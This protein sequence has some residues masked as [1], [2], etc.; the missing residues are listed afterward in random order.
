MPQTVANYLI[1]MP[2][3]LIDDCVLVDFRPGM[4]VE[5][6]FRGEEDHR[7]TFRFMID[8]YEKDP[9][10]AKYEL[11]TRRN[12]VLLRLEYR[13][14]RHQNPDGA[15]VDCPHL[16]TYR[17]GYSDRWAEPVS[18]RFG[19]PQK[20]LACLRGFLGYCNLVQFPK[21]REERGFFS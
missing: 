13:A 6:N 5:V 19:D 10:H 17:E 12:V 9:R 21:L 2:K 18:D 7:E 3:V 15:L 4:K 20:L 11:M 8:R 1:K 14:S 16:H